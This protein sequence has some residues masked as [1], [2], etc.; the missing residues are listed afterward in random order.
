MMPMARKAL[1]SE[2]RP[3]KRDLLKNNTNMH[4]YHTSCDREAMSRRVFYVLRVPV[5]VNRINRSPVLAT[6]LAA[7]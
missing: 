6:V 1:V 3:Y 5:L 2:M 4:P 7:S